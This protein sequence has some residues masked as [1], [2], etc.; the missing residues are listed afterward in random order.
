MEHLTS[1][2]VSPSASHHRAWSGPNRL[3]VMDPADP[4]RSDDAM[5]RRGAARLVLACVA[6]A[7]ACTP[8][9]RD[10]GVGSNANSN[11]TSHAT[12][13]AD[14]LRGFAHLASGEWTTTLAS[15]DILRETWRWEPDGRSL[16]V[17]G[18]GGTPDGRP[19]REEQVFFVND[20]S[21][22]VRVR[23]SNSYRNS[24]FEGTVTFGDGTAE[25][26]FVL[27]QDAATRQLVRRWRF[28]GEDRFETELLEFVFGE[29][30]VP[31]TSWTY[32]RTRGPSSVTP[33]R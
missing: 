3:W 31:L 18:V 4:F 5:M 11:A 16:R 29:G 23:G 24:A 15:G 20:D 8:V 17:L 10:A 19:W 1:T 21:G 30:L 22:E 13:D 14:R 25:A 7:G 26:R 27:T 6:L 9:A 33:S 12:A 32:T 28:E 2:D